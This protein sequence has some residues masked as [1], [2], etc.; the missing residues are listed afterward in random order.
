MKLKHAHGKTSYPTTRTLA[1]S[2]ID[3]AKRDAEK[4]AKRST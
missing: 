2:A 3:A 4:L 1:Q